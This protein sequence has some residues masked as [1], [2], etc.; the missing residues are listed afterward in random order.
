[1]DKIESIKID[2][3]KKKGNFIGQATIF[4]ADKEVVLLDLND[5]TM[6]SIITALQN[7]TISEIKKGER[8]DS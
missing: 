7:Y 4:C 3:S 8:N 6:E 2:L 5:T 1:M